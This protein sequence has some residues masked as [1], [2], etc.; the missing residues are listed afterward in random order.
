MTNEY[1]KPITKIIISV[2]AKLEYCLQWLR[3]GAVRVVRSY[4]VETLLALYACIRCLL[5]Y[6]LDWSEERLFNGLAFVPL[7]F[8]LALAVNNLAG[9]GPWRKVYWA[10]WT[11]IVPLTL[12]SGLGAWVESA[13][14]RISLGILA[15]LLL[16]LSLRAVRNDR[17]VNGALVWLRSG[18]LALLFANVALGLFYAILYSTTY[19]FGLEG[20]WIEHVA[21]WAVTIVETLAVPVLFLM[22]ADRWRGAEMIGNRILEILL[23]YI[24]TPALLIYTAILYLYM[25]KILFTWSLPEGGVAYMVFGFTMTAL[26]VKALDRL[27]AKRIYDWF[28]DRFSLV[29]L[30]M[31]VLFW[32]GVVRRTNEYG[33]TESRVY[34]LVCGG[35]MTFCVLLFLSQRAGRYLW[36]CLAAWVSF[37][38][39]AYVPCF[40]PERI[41][42]QSQLQRAE[43]LAERLGRLGEDG[44]LLLT[45]VP[46]AD[47]VRREEYRN[48][49]ESLDYIRRDS[50]AFA[51]FGVERD[52]DDLAAIFPEAMRDY[53]RWG[54]DWSRVDTCVD[55]NIIELEAPVNVRFEVNAE[56]PHYYTNL[57]NWYND[58]SYD[59]SNDTLRLFLGEEC[60]VYRISCRDLL[61]RQLERSG[62]DPA[63]A[64]EPTSEQLLRLLDYRDDRCRILFENIKLERTDST[65]VIQGVSINAVLMR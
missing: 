5:T 1:A 4:P 42:V 28:F 65:V 8:A 17:F 33:L 9:R 59:V 60:A 23:N 52:L 62:F 26:A 50:A 35:L 29:S 40:E 16:L 25:A 13:P 21:V 63:E 18:L 64:C 32:I 53:V 3:D 10:V 22:M 55:T 36:V 46:L 14:F 45:P 24:V 48:L 20:K 44:R 47:T 38:V 56:Y 39:L 34:L 19:I 57:R 37:A 30:P 61:E 51:R 31:L 7:F 58:H 54:Y 27:L 15:P 49:Y 11:P 41:A 2:K 6:E 43:R 12:W